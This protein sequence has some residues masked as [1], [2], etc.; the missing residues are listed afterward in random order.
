MKPVQQAIGYGPG[1]RSK[2]SVTRREFL[3]GDH[4]ALVTGETGVIESIS[5]SGSITIVNDYKIE[6]RK[7]QIA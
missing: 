4:V 5:A 7:E 1:M 3:P 2:R 6:V